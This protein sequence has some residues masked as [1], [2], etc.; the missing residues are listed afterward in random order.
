MFETQLRGLVD[1]LA[2]AAKARSTLQVSIA[3]LQAAFLAL[4]QC[5]LSSSLRKLYDQA[6]T[7]QQK[8]YDLGAAQAAHDERVGSLLSVAESYARMCA[9]AK[10]CSSSPS[11]LT[12]LNRTDLLVCLRESLGRASRHITHGRPPS[13]PC[14]SSTR[15]TRRR[16]GAGGR[17][18]S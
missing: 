7:V 6:A 2:A 9:S 17:I 12:L 8:L 1:K 13:R 18:P 3:E 4:S 5:D 10:V 14:G 11:P 15:S 16:S